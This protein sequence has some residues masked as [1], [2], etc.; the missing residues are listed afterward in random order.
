MAEL[1]A[2]LLST[3]STLLAAGQGDRALSAAI[4]T[5]IEKKDV[6]VI[7][8][9]AVSTSGAAKGKVSAI[10]LDLDGLLLDP[11]VID[12]SSIVVKDVALAGDGKMSL[13]SINWNA[14]I[15][16]DDL[17]SALQMHVDK[18][19]DATLKISDGQLKLHGSYPLL[20]VKVPYDVAGKLSVENDTQLV[21]RIDRSG[22]SGIP[23]PRGLNKLIE[24]EINPV[25][26]L[27]EFA[28]RN[29]G[30]ITSAREKFNYEFKL[31]IDSITNGDGHII[32]AGTA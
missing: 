1:I 13:A 6:A 27:A 21:F 26:D 12:E 31:A 2:L 22:V 18:L 3:L 29:E 11:L 15:S 5:A 4:K 8:E 17:T 30:E 20:G 23:M 28:E 32:V 9:L 24:S 7:E 19:S 25:Y 14:T 10:N 16:E